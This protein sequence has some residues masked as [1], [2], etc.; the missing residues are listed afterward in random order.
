MMTAR[1]L[2]YDVV[3]DLNAIY[4]SSPGIISKPRRYQGIRPMRLRS[5]AK[6]LLRV[7]TQS[8]LE[9]DETA[10]NVAGNYISLILVAK[11]CFFFR[12]NEALS[13]VTP[14]VGNKNFI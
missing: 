4:F 14:C 8:D 5:S 10:V 3:D 1:L 2:F 7:L 12:E 9:V 13:D 11:A 6:N